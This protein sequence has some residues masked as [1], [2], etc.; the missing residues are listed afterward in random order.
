[1]GKV[2]MPVQGMNCEH[3]ETSVTAAPHGLG[4]SG[5]DP[6]SRRGR[7]SADFGGDLVP[8]ADAIR[9]AGYAPGRSTPSPRKPPRS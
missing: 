1:M 6:G 5:A 7:A 4:A 8:L 3:C 9:L 2:Q